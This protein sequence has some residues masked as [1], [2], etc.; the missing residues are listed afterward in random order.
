MGLQFKATVGYFS[1]SNLSSVNRHVILDKSTSALNFLLQFDL[2]ASFTCINSYAYNYLLIVFPFLTSIWWIEQK[3]KPSVYQWTLSAWTSG[4]EPKY[5]HYLLWIWFKYI[6][7]ICIPANICIPFATGPGNLGSILGRV[8]PKTQKWYLMPLCLT[9]IIIRY[10]SRVSESNQE[11]G[12]LRVALD[13][14]I[15]IYIY[16]ENSRNI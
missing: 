12:S 5:F 13:Y 14:R 6:K 2:I 1:Y 15:Y 8:L 10:R 11:K 7:Y 4:G 16:T 9:L 3:Q